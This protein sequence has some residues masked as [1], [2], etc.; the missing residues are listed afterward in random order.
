MT[1]FSDACRTELWRDFDESAAYPAIRPLLAHYTTLPVLEK[2]VINDELWFSHPLLM[3]DSEEM[4]WGLEQGER[5]FLSNENIK[6]ACGSDAR[7]KKLIEDF[8]SRYIQYTHMTAATT[9]VACFCRHD[10]TNDKDGILSMWRGY[11]GNGSGVALIFDTQH[12]NA[13]DDTPF[14]LAPIGYLSQAERTAHITTQIDS[15]AQVIRLHNPPDDQV[16]LASGWFMERLK[17]FSL[18]TKHDGFNEEKEWRLAY[19]GDRDTEEHFHDMLGYLITERGAQP[20]L[21]LK[22]GPHPGFKDPELSMEKLAH[23]VLL[24]P[25]LAGRLNQLAIE[26]MLVLANKPKL[27]MAVRVSGIPYRP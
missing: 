12:L 20:K 8:N 27:R 16:Y 2:I 23:S 22:I 13:R 21:K 7:Y 19:M 11:G 26:R 6:S 24:G 10:D 18:F 25:S 3:T 4:R 17:L 5:L 1:N 15:L 14:V 9:Y